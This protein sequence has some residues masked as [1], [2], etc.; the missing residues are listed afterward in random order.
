MAGWGGAPL[1]GGILLEKGDRTYDSGS[2]HIL[3]LSLHLYD[4]PTR[5]PSVCRRGP[6]SS[7]WFCFHLQYLGSDKSRCL[8]TFVICNRNPQHLQR[9]F[10]EVMSC[11]LPQSYSQEIKDFLPSS[12]ASLFLPSCLPMPSFPCYRDLYCGAPSCHVPTVLTSGT[13][14]DIP[15][16]A[17]CRDPCPQRAT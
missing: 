5:K 1:Q 16:S 10:M 14:K 11:L 12:P 2:S 13:L 17:G 6:C 15:D 9:L 7:A 4:S 8:A 3:Q